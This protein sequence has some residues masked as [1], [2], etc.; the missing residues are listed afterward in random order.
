MSN[1]KEV[2][3]LIEQNYLRTESVIEY[4]RMIVKL[5]DGKWINKDILLQTVLAYQSKNQEFIN[6][7]AT[8]VVMSQINYEDMKRK[9]K[10]YTEYFKMVNEAAEDTNE[11]LTKAGLK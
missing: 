5:N 1:K 4:D 11:L 7:L 6:E 10:V 8:I 9:N 3:S 2:Q